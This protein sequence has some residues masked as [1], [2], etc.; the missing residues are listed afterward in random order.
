MRIHLKISTIVIQKFDKYNIKK[1]IV[2]SYVLINMQKFYVAIIEE[3]HTE[4]L[5][6]HLRIHGWFAIEKY[7]NV[8]FA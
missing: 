8:N 2:Q 1:S 7:R 5:L 3:Q 4:C 6:W